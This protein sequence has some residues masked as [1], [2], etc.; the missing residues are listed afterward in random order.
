MIAQKRGALEFQ[1]GR[2]ALHFIF[3][4]SQQ[5]RDVEIATR[6]ANDGRF[7]FA[8]AQNCVQTLLHGAADGLRRDPVRFVIF[9]LFHPPIFRNRHERFHAV[10]DLI[11]EQNNFAIDVTRSAA[12][13]LDERRL[14]AQKAF[15]VGIENADERDLG[16]IE[17]FAE[18]INPDEDIEVSRTQSAQNF[19]ALDRVDVAM[20]IAYFQSDV[21]QIIG[22]ILG[23]ALR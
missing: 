9:H 21:A 16:K 13:G 14:A 19:H 10:R 7:D 17:T 22:Q 2:G 3:E 12:G 1:I 8:P 5:L 23:R 11:G 18:Q 20:Q 15:L 6:F 4:L